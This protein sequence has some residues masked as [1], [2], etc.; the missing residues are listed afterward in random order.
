[1]G[2][3][4]IW[5][6][7]KYIFVGGA[8]GGTALA[9][10][11]ARVALL[12]IVAKITAPKL[13]LSG[14]AQTKTFTIK[15]SIAPQAFIYGEDLISGPMIFA[16]VATLANENRD[17]YVL[18]AL[19]GHEVDSVTAYRIDSLDIPLTD[20]S[21]AEDGD[22]ISG[23]YNGV[24]RVD[25][26]HGTS[27]QV[28]I[29]SLDTVFTSPDLFNSAHTGRGWS[30]MLWEFNL[31]EGSEAVFKNT[32]QNLRA[33]IKGRKIYDPR[34]DSTNGG[35]GPHRLADDTTWEWSH[36][37][38]LCLADFIRDD[39]FGMR[40]E[41]DRIDWPM[42]ITAAD[43][44]EELVAIPVAS[45]Q[46]RYT[47]NATFFAT[48][49]RGEVRD[50]LLGSM[51]GRMVFSQGLWK[52]WAG[53]AVVS[54][55][56][57]T[58]ANLAGGIQMEASTPSRERYNRVRGKFVDASRDYTA[59]AYPEQRSSTF[60]T[61]DGGEVREIVADFTSTNNSFEA[62]RKAIIFLK[63]SRNQR[64]VVFQGNY[65]C[66]RIQPGATVTLT[67]DEYGFAGE[68]F[69]VTQWALAPDGIELT[70]VEEVDSVWSDPLEGDYTVRTETGVLVFGDTGVP[71]PTG[72]VAVTLQ[73][74]ALLTWTNPIQSAFD[75]IEIHAANENVRG[76]AVIIG[77]TQAETFYEVLVETQRTRYYWIRAVNAFGQVSDFE[78][79]L[80]TTTASVFPQIVTTPLVADP[81]IRLGAPFWD[82]SG[83][84]WAYTVGS[85]LNGTDVLEFL[86]P[87][88]G[89]GRD[90]FTAK[91]RG[92][93]IWDAMA[94]HGAAIELRYR[95]RVSLT[96]VGTWS[97]GLFPKIYVT[98]LDGV[99]NPKTYTNTAS[100]TLFTDA[101]VQG[102]WF[103]FAIVIE[104]DDEETE[105]PP[106]F[107]QILFSGSAAPFT[108]RFELDFIDAT[109][110]PGIFAPSATTKLTVGLVPDSGGTLLGRVLT[111]DGGW[112]IN[113]GGQKQGRFTFDTATAA[114][115]PG[116]G[117]IRFNNATLASVTALYVSATDADGFDS[118][119][120]FGFLATG[121]RIYYE[122]AGNPSKAAIFEVSSA[123]TDNTGWWTIPVTVIA[124]DTLPSNG[125]S[126]SLNI[127]F[128][129]GG[130]GGGAFNDLT[131]VDL[132][133]AADN[134]MLFR[135]G[136]NWID[137]AGL[138][139]WDGLTLNLTGDIHL[140][141]DDEIQLGVAAGGDARIYWV[142]A[143]ND[144][145]IDIP[146]GA[147]L[148]M[149]EI[150]AN[151]FYLYNG[152]TGRH[153]W[154]NGAGN[155]NMSTIADGMRAISDADV[156]DTVSLTHDGTDGNLIGANAIDLNITG[157]TR[158][159]HD[160]SLSLLESVSAP[161]DDTTYGQFW[162]RDDAPGQTP[163]FTDDAGVDIDLG[164]MLLGTV[165]DIT[166]AKEFQDNVEL[167]F[168]TGNDVQMYFNGTDLVLE[169]VGGADFRLRG[170]AAL[171]DMIVAIQDGAVQ[172]FFNDSIKLATVIGGTHLTGTMF[173]QEQATD[174]TSITNSGQ[175]WVRSD[176]TQTPMFTADNDTEFELNAGEPGTVTSIGITP[177]ALIDVTGSPVTVSGNITVDVDLS[178]LTDM[179]AAAVTTDEMVLL[180]AGLQRRK[181]FSE[182][183]LSIFNDDL[184]HVENVTHTS[185]VTGATALTVVVAAITGQAELLS[186]L[187][188]TD[189][190]LLSNAGVIKRMDV[191]VMNAYFDA[192]LNFSAPGH[193]HTGSTISALD[194]GDTTTG[195]FA[196]ARIPTHTGHVTGQ[197]SLSVGIAAITGQIDIGANLISTDEVLVNA[198]GSIRRADIS[199]FNNY[200]N[201]NLT[202]GSGEG[203]MLLGTV[204][205]IT[206]AKE[207]NDNVELR[208][209]SGNDVQMYYAS[210]G[211]DLRID[212][213]SGMDLRMHEGADIFY[214]FNGSTGFHGFYN[215]TGNLYMATMTDGM[216]AVAGADANDGVAITHSGVDGFINVQNGGILQMQLQ[217]TTEL[218]LQDGN[219]SDNITGA[220]VNWRRTAFYD[221]G[222]AVMPAISKA[223]ALNI[224][225]LHMHKTIRI[226]NVTGSIT[227]L[228]DTGMK[229]DSVGWIINT[230]TSNQVLAHTSNN[231]E[232]FS[233]DGAANNTGDMTL[234]G[235][236]W[237]TWRKLSDTEYELVGVGL[238]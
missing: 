215:A 231:L 179:T 206:A 122:V 1:M 121:N 205:S 62:Q 211:N 106:R 178:E 126:M 210:A 182:I 140:G 235:K 53:E 4:N 30:Y 119:V 190:L 192:N 150:G 24:A 49:K 90:V 110:V 6:F 169:M 219:N 204:Q 199:R 159:K 40:E 14:R 111:D 86:V 229:I 117:D 112:G 92:P 128:Q 195:T 198:G 160:G 120:V 108:I 130:G 166:A 85:G 80:T 223:S 232:V 52:M 225:E 164:D 226:T 212:L 209:G 102:D 71:A 145:R 233:G 26:R 237:C 25:F 142:G 99:S 141:D 227:F 155:L 175:F 59:A 129:V 133:G 152:A 20:L 124:S 35:S 103:D 174:N 217:G 43:V 65:S 214:L 76:S 38:A 11:L 31:V 132:T 9:V 87:M 63:Q 72:L 131:D 180:D 165:Q 79:D 74:G 8:T 93:D 81:F 23:D 156:N 48:E 137:T 136:G 10:N 163:M 188:G 186:G 201:N 36:N 51:I 118:D 5:Q 32:P 34:L 56:T 47:C 39:K 42:V 91:R 69:F 220:E 161:T 84:Q 228:N 68:K 16:N 218:R 44:C 82:V 191:S 15:D 197:T 57:L 196:A 158:L 172:L 138:L 67:I 54:D 12:A 187:A 143:G 13:D 148:R 194:A 123:P 202:F 153:G 95:A 109:F 213:A 116:S 176:A 115:D 224:S 149:H 236:G 135:S 78:P 216:R 238:S 104:L 27:T 185:Q 222:L 200:F 183:N 234:A 184:G 7:I 89:G 146:S 101:T 17:L 107:I 77:T 113:P 171:D 134:D 88:S 46:E 37:P 18:V 61:E 45:T 64:V 55:V 154:Y 189:E 151:I 125:N 208:F 96:A 221:V 105:T 73:N 41:D 3:G 28:V 19:T 173:L 181:A 66:F 193:T 60:V 33:L 83:S 177:G 207:F 50:E 29:P 162:V 127:D 100:T 144:L 230:T 170:G 114:A 21:G 157:F 75:H 167:R 98:D 139:T 94:S 2:W 168:G 58:E 203:D 97:L 147:D 22:V 70:M